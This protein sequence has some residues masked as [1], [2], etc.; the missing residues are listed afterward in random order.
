MAIYAHSSSSSQHFS[1][2]GLLARDQ[3]GRIPNLGLDSVEHLAKGKGMDR[4]ILHTLYHDGLRNC[5]LAF[6]TWNS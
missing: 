2:Q 6:P 3:R 1:S 5:A 4:S